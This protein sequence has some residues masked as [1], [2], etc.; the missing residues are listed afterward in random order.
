M[1]LFINWL[2]ED[3]IGKWAGEEEVFKPGQFKWMENWKAKH[4]AKHL[5]SQHFNKLDKKTDHFTRKELEEKCIDGKEETSK[6][7]MK[8]ELYNKNLEKPETTE[9]TTEKIEKSEVKFEDLKEKT[10]AK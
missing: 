6:S 4:Y 5:V 9:K 3:F 8:S 1:I 10:D 2:T 7:N